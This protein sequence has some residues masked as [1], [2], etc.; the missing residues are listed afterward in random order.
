MIYVFVFDL[1]FIFFENLSTRQ[2][3]DALIPD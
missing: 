2:K 1:T 3:P